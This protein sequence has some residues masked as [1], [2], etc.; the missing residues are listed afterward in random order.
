MLDPLL[1]SFY[2]FCIFLSLGIIDS[3]V[4][5]FPESDVGATR[6]PH[7]EKLRS[8]PVRRKEKMKTKERGEEEEKRNKSRG[9]RRV[10]K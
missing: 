6:I 1:C 2:F 3:P 9:E 4:S 5:E 8:P 10:E 7:S